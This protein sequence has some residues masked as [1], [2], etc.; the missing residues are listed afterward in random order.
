MKVLIN[1]TMFLGN[2]WCGECDS[3][4][5]TGRAS[6]TGMQ[7][8]AKLVMRFPKTVI[9]VILGITLAFGYFIPQVKFNNDAGEFIPPDDPA[10]LYNNEVEDIFGNDAVVYIGLVTDN[11][12]APETLAKI[13]E[14]TSELENIE[15]VVEVTSLSTV[16]NIEGTFDGMEVYP[17]L[18][19]DNLPETEEDGLHIRK[20]VESWEILM[21]NLVSD[22]GKATSIVVELE[23][24][25]DMPTEKRVVAEVGAIIDRYRAPGESYHYSGITPINV[26]LGEY[27]LNDIKHLLP[28]AFLV[29]AITLYLSFRNLN[30]VLLPLVNVG[31][32]IIW[33]IGLMAFLGVELS[34]P[35]TAIPV[36]LVAVGSAYA[37][38]V[39]HDYYDELKG[40]LVKE[41]ALQRCLEKVGMAVIMAGLTTVAGFGTLLVSKVI[42][43]QDFGT[44]VAF[45]T[46]A[47]L[48][49]AL[50]FVPAVLYLEHAPN[51]S[52]GA[53][54]QPKQT[55]IDRF[56]KG[57]LRALV[58]TVMRHRGATVLVAV[59]L[60]AVGVWGTSKM[61]VND[62]A[63]E[64]FHPRTEVRKDNN[65]LNEY[66]AGTR[67]VS[68]IIIGPEADSMKDPHILSDI[69]DLQQHMQTTFPV[70][71]KTMSL[72]DYVKKMNMAMN[73]NQAEFY[74]LPDPDDENSRD[75]VAQ[76]L[77]LYSM[78]GDPEDFDGVV[79]Y[80]YRQARVI[81]QAQEGGTMQTQAMIDEILAY[82]KA[83]FDSQYE[84]RIAGS[85]YTHLIMD[86][87]VV[88]GFKWSLIVSLI[89]VW[90]LTSLIFRS[91]F[92]GFLAVMPLSLAVL[93]NFAVMGF[94]NV[95]LEIGTSIVANAA[96]GIGVDYAI[97]FLSRLRH[98][99]CGLNSGNISENMLQ[100]AIVTATTAGQAILF[101]AIAVAAGFL[102]LTF[103]LFVPLIR[104]G[105]L[106]A[107]VMGTTSLG[108]ILLL[109]VLASLLKPKF[110]V[111][112]VRVK[113]IRA[114]AVEARS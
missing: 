19:A 63:I 88:D 112:S 87:Y 113:G 95:P 70:I 114:N 97:H 28:V 6:H 40:G 38:H 67:V 56:S 36:I 37:I 7:W 13:A 12:Y 50:L 105:G 101:N 66:F 14:L 82:T 76:Y 21:N 92:G 15:G 106:V 59:L 42:P 11:V 32:A 65:V 72:A 16:N 86:H 57:L 45:G 39:I 52:K 85:A 100:A 89:V 61:E 26:F 75:L 69:A 91:V 10:E 5:D 30:G 53:G 96:I 25:P 47:S 108:S 107:L 60:C 34:L 17:L 98:E 24:H 2:V 111:N 64:Y 83:H 41:D 48:V 68:A 80:E 81:F 55:V 46:L 110:L 93:S 62:N 90:I 35:C 20:Q 8:I 51:M 99:L 94:F 79:D 49:L 43:L 9:V 29:V 104:L 109:P 27:M 22:D 77:L 71:G 23:P 73:E 78:S 74:R 44:F 103:S 1:V 84:V 3:K 58:V 31:I 18:D 4:S 33:T 54:R 102:V